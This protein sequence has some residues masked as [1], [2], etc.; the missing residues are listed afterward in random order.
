MPI[1]NFVIELDSTDI[2]DCVKATDERMNLIKQNGYQHRSTTLTVASDPMNR[3]G[4]YQAFVTE[5]AAARYFGVQYN[6]DIGPDG[7]RKD[8]VN[9]CQ[10]RS[11]LHRRGNLIVYEYDKPAPFIL[12]IPLESGHEIVLAGW[13][14]LVDCRLEKYW[15][16][17]PAVRQQSWWIPQH[18]LHDMVSL[19]A[20][21]MLV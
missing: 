6:F 1:K 5:L 3:A 4:H 8:L 15:R 14:D 11:T 10:V 16:T 7:L 21:M 17:T 12:A 2:A 9:G 20:K 13:R 18:D 19:K